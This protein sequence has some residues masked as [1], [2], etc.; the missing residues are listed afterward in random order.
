METFIGALVGWLLQE[1][2]AAGRRRFG[3][4]VVRV[5]TRVVNAAI[6]QAVEQIYVDAEKR[7]HV[8]AL[9]KERPAGTLPLVDGAPLGQLATAVGQWVASI[10]TPVDEDGPPPP[11]TNHPLALAL[12][13][14]ILAGIQREALRGEGVLHPLWTD[15]QQAV[16]TGKILA[17]IEDVR[18]SVS[19]SPGGGGRGRTDRPARID[20]WHPPVAHPSRFVGRDAELAWLS[21]SGGGQLRLVYGI[22]GVGKT[23]LALAFADRLGDAFPDGR[24]F[25]DFQS[26][27]E[28]PRHH[29]KS[30]EQAL[31]ELLPLCGIDDRQVAGMDLP[32]RELLW[33]QAISGRRMLF[34]WDNVGSLVQIEP[35]VTVQPGCLTL[36][37]SRSELEVPAGSLKLE[38]LSEQEAVELFAAVA[39]GE[40]DR[41]DQELILDAVRLCA[42]MPLQIM[43]HAAS[44]RHRRSLPELVTELARLP[45][46]DRL[47]RLFASLDL[48]YQDLP[49]EVRRAWR[50]LGAHPGPHLTA[51]T[52]AAMLNCA[53]EEAV[54]LLDELVNANF[55]E[56]YRGR[57]DRYG[58][59]HEIASE[60]RFYAYTAHD[61]LR[62]YARHR[63]AQAADELT[64]HIQ[65]LLDHYWE[66]L[67][68]GIDRTWIQV[69]RACI[70]LALWLV[71]PNEDI[72]DF[73]HQA[74]HRLRETGWYLDAEVA[75]GYALH[76]NRETQA[77]E[78]EAYALW[79]LAQ[80]SITRGDHEQAVEHLQ[81]A[82][83]INREIGNRQGEADVLTDLGMMAI[84]QGHHR[85]GLAT[86][87]EALALT[88]ELA[89]RN[90]EFRVQLQLAQMRLS[91]GAM[92]RADLDRAARQ[93]RALLQLGQRLG[94]ERSRA[95]ALLFLAQVKEMQQANKAAA[96]AYQSALEIFQTVGHR[97][98]Q[99]NALFGIGSVTLRRGDYVQAATRCRMALAIYREISDR[100]GEAK[101]LMQMAEIAIAGGAL[102]EATKLLHDAH[103]MYRQSGSPFGQAATAKRLAEVALATGQQA[104]ARAHIRESLSLLE[105]INSP[106]ADKVRQ[107][108]AGLTR[109]SAT[110]E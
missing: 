18:R 93:A 106:H 99:A 71:E 89:D 29:R 49:E 95:S 53:V 48:S 72:R 68:T 5:L 87:E 66:R 108:L 90:R 79:S 27:S 37:T 59:G 44:V 62:D 98:G 33:K 23:A 15:Y 22:G 32:Q 26:Y 73:A 45:T 75:D 31:A 16:D 50:V 11:V 110:R 102:G 100:E 86:L 67:T 24:V 58:G 55:A 52:A 14:E 19:G 35:L 2:G 13:R 74:G 76:L 47:A 77:R 61:L 94:D 42:W 34:V 56:R 39:A 84:F 21:A 12:C 69:E 36:I 46:G 7:E 91:L 4:Q 54:G 57:F 38:H 92:T 105:A 9:L 3:D 96:E 10:E 8:I 107:Q 28:H 83:S 41:L 40:S 60:P 20:Y 25:V 30:A 97:H 82:L 64:A 101:T 65:R 43:V 6:S 109:P 104:Q 1:A 51:G 88:R 103:T 78:G 17:S 85:E 70:V 63:A 81:V 80:A